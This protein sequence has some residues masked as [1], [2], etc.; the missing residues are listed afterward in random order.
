MFL[1]R[2]YYVALLL[3]AAGTALRLIYLREYS[4][5]PL[6]YIPIGPDFQEYDLWARKIFAGQLFWNE[7]PIHGP[8]YSFFLAG[9]FRFFTIDYFSIRLAQLLIGLLAAVPL[10]V[11]LSG[12]KDGSAIRSMVPEIFLF[13]CCV[14]PPLIFYEGEIVSEALLIPLL[15]LC[16]Y[17]IYRA[18]EK[19]NFMKK[20]FFSF[21]GLCC[22][23]AVITHPVSIFFVFAETAYL[24]FRGKVRKNIGRL[25]FFGT[26]V[27]LPVLSVSIYNSLL[28]GKPTFVQA[29]GGFNFFLGNNPDSTGSCYIRPGPEWDAAHRKAEEASK[30]ENIS[31]DT[32][33]LHKSLSFFKE[34]PLQA[35]LNFIRKAVLTW[36]YRE[37]SAGADMDLFRYFT[38]FQQMGRL[39]FVFLGIAALA[40]LLVALSR[41][42]TLFE[43]RHFIILALSF[44]FAQTLFVTSGRYR[45]SMLPA[46]FVLAAFFISY[47]VSEKKNLSNIVRMLFPAVLASL[48]VLFPS[49]SL[50]NHKKE[51]AEAMNIL[52]EVSMKRGDYDS[53]E[54]YIQES[55]PFYYNWSRTFNMLGNSLYA[56]QRP[57]EALVMYAQAQKLDP[58]D[59]N[60]SMNTAIM[61]SELGDYKTAMSYFK[62]AFDK[63][64]KSSELFYNYAVMLMRMGRNDDALKSFSVALKIDPSHKMALNN[65]GIILFTK[66]RSAEAVNYFRKSLSLDPSNASLM[67]NLAAALYSSGKN[68][69]ADRWKAR[70]IRL[71]PDNP[72]VKKLNEIPLKK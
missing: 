34:N 20:I 72:N 9:L 71:D 64:N 25:L 15:C 59:Y 69:E 60:A 8:F 12:K 21:S 55:L 51:C 29:N 66:G 62:T 19:E 48:V 31:Q 49:G 14:Y 18:E 41:K 30:K 5:S 39:S 4:G 70:T 10:Y 65:M 33:F 32:Y 38:S 44:W 43:Y 35:A 6:F 26:A 7:V 56:R 24:A 53:A 61:Y 52:A 22:G 67:V 3:L 63:E 11:Y 13:L 40:G 47:I 42:E 27:A 50:V 23:L 2:T 16:V 54:K 58:E 1:K 28:S 36:N 57:E 46:L 17:F 45:V 37:F 68:F